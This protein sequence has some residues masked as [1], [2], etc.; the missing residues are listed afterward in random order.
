MVKVAM[1][2]PFRLGGPEVTL[3]QLQ[4]LPTKPDAL[5]VWIGDALKHSDVRSSAGKLDAAMQDRSVF[6]G[7]ISLVS[8]HVKAAPVDHPV[9][10]SGLC[11]TVDLAATRMREAA[12]GEQTTSSVGDTGR[13][14][15]AARTPTS[16]R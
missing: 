11:K 9:L 5:K 2:I 16:R 1:S 10:R 15:S 3:E 7:L 8:Q 6:D 14:G 13:Q 4:N 12:I